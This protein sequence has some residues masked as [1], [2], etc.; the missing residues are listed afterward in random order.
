ME[1]MCFEKF[2]GQVV[3]KEQINEIIELVETFPKLSRTELANTVCELFS[4]KRPTGKLKS[5]ECRQFL[6]RLDENGVLCLPACRSQF[7]KKSK[8]KVSRTGKANPQAVI[9]GELK[10]LLPILLDRV[11]TQAQRQ[12]W[13]EYVDRY[14]YLG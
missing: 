13:Y 8:T 5:V 14:H 3:K 10:V 9:S 7:A 1:V 2:C 4:W 6:E 12:L 11:K